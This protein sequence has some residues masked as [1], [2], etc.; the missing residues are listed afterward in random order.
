[1]AA[2]NKLKE[3]QANPQQTTEENKGTTEVKSLVEQAGLNFDGFQDEYINSG[4]LSEE[5]YQKLEKAGFPK[6]IVD[7][8]I[9]GLKASET[10]Q[11]NELSELAGGSDN[12]NKILEWAAKSLA[13]DEIESYNAI[14][15]TGDMKQVS[16]AL[17]G[18]K[19]KYEAALGTM[20]ATT[21]AGAQTATAPDIFNSMEDVQKAMSDE[22]YWTDATYNAEV[23]EK[24]RR[25]IL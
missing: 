20:N 1:M 3:T 24:L 8:H 23:T 7:A 16:L 12:L 4:Q 15:E 2:Y 17:T 14:T 11:M 13:A 6:S 21:Y 18:L 5:S 10:L 19:A 22:R 25:S 9:D